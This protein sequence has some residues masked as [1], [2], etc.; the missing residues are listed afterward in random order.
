MERI[1]CK[2]ERVGKVEEGE[3]GE[4]GNKRDDDG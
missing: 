1:R 2:D 4:T 3:K